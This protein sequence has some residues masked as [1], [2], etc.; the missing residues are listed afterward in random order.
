MQDAVV[1]D[2]RLLDRLRAGDA[3]AF[4]ALVRTWSP[5]LLRYARRFVATDASAQ[6]V[7]QETWLAV[8]R[9]LD[10]F[11]A[12]SSL[13]TWVFAIL[14][15]QARRRGVADRRTVPVATLS[16]ED[17]P[18]VDPERFLPAGEYWADAW[19][20]GRGPQS[21]GPEAHVLS[22][23]VRARLLEA[24]EQLPSRQREVVV[25]RDVLGLSGEEVATQLGLTLGNVRVLLHRGRVKVRE[26]LE[27]YWTNHSRPP[28]PRPA[29][30]MP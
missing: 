1:D 20:P 16:D 2:D 24:L 30:S 12:D 3:A 13:R 8:V 29:G 25:L 7:V 6:E 26:Q 14:V 19:R 23:E 9:G 5:Q 18:A 21:W 28:R 27:D 10:R 15:N 4:D 17:G 11:R 22:Q